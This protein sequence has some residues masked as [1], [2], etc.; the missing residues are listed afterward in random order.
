MF[1]MGVMGRAQE[2]PV[3]PPTQEMP[4][5]PQVNP[6][7]KPPIPPRLMADSC[8]KAKGMCTH[9]YHWDCG[10]QWGGCVPN[11]PKGYR[12]AS[13]NQDVCTTAKK[14]C[15]TILPVWPIVRNSHDWGWQAV[16]CDP[17]SVV[18]SKVD[19]IYPESALKEKRRDIVDVWAHGNED[20]KVTFDICCGDFGAA[21]NAAL[22]QWQWRPFLLNG[23]PIEFRMRIRYAFE[24]TPNGPLVRMLPER[25]D[26]PETH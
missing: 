4:K 19:P 20:A 18:L 6:I 1:A 23:R 14:P 9:G 15:V 2:P 8:S 7:P 5:L 26:A 12:A 11:C 16:L 24:L 3:L 25:S 17:S 10:S 13:S 21:V 22:K